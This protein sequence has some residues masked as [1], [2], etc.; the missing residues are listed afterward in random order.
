[1]L[2]IACGSQN[3]V[4]G[5]KK[6]PN[7]DIILSITSARAIPSMVTYSNKERLYGSEAQAIQKS[8]MKG[9]I[10]YPMRML[11]FQPEWNGFEL[12]Q[13][14]SLCKP[15]VDKM[16]NRSVYELEYKDKMVNIYPEHAM[17]I[18]F[19]KIKGLFS[20][21]K[22]NRDVSVSVPDFFSVNERQAMIDAVKVADLKLIQL[23]NESSANTLNYGLFRKAQLD[24][25]I[26]RVV[27]F[28]DVGQ[29]KTSVFYSSFTKNHNKVV[30]VTNE[31]N[32]GARDMD[33][34]LVEHYAAIFNKQHSCNPMKNAKCI[35]R[36]LDTVQQSRKILTGNKETQVNIESWMDDEDLFMTLKREEFEVIVE[37]IINKIRATIIKSLEDAK[38]KPS[39]IHSIE[40]V[41]EACRTPIVQAIA[42]EIFSKEV[43]KTLA[44]DESIARGVTI[45]SALSSP[46]FQIK[47]YTFEHFNNYTVLIEYPFIKEGQ[48]QIRT[49]KI[50]K[51]GD[52]FPTK[53]SIKFT[54]KQL[55]QE[56]ILNIKLKYDETEV[57][58]LKNQVIN[59]YE[60]HLP[61]ITNDKFEFVLHFCMDINGMPYIE[62]SALNEYWFEEV[63]VVVSKPEEKKDEKK[64][65]KKEEKK[66]DKKMDVEPE[67]KKVRKDRAHQCIINIV[68]QNYAIS[69][70]VLDNIISSEGQQEKDD[71]DLNYCQFKRNEVEQFIYKTKDKLETSDLGIY[72][73]PDELSVL[74][75]QMEEVQKWF[76]SED[77]LLEDM[78]TL[79]SKT[80]KL[81]DL[82][83]AIYKR[84]YEWENVVNALQQM[85]QLLNNVEGQLFHDADRFNKKDPKCFLSEQD[86]QELN[87]NHD[88]YKK[89]TQEAHKALQ[90]IPRTSTPP[91]VDKT[92]FQYADDINKKINSIYTAAETKVREA[93]RKEEEAKKALEKKA[94]E[95]KEAEEAKNKKENPVNTEEPKQ[96]A[97]T[98]STNTTKDESN[99]NNVNM[100]VD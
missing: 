96:D 24:E 86:F 81:N 53:K 74:Q 59:S 33:Y 23:V 87:K 19:N 95:E 9:T 46:L 3:T 50:I 57:P 91:V 4:I 44:P 93:Q 34:A 29:S 37:P 52:A 85:G 8:N 36:M 42:K 98:N 69:R 65:D 45:F 15:I 72:I 76:Y 49:H 35:L 31:R 41:G 83:Q 39:D 84:F 92:I 55:P 67:T 2:G 1:M 70:N 66:D 26:P 32:C 71:K 78:N 73:L 22:E 60:I 10:K 77:P 14:Y 25:K 63:P 61:K 99:T 89:K 20:S 17:G 51:K 79:D 56:S 21:V 40:M 13:K 27:A 28:L 6:G 68:E 5:V 18:Y 88:L 82:G 47:D 16:T 94:R 97:A 100:E 80:Q 30:S 12:E 54:E 90:G 11:G 38:L 7:V 58:H 43:S 75:V 48:V 64:D 62:K